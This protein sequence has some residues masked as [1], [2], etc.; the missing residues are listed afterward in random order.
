MLLLGLL[1]LGTAVLFLAMRAVAP[2]KERRA[3]VKVPVAVTSS[4]PVVV[5]TDPVPPV[6]DGKTPPP[7]IAVGELNP[8]RAR[9][10]GSACDARNFICVNNSA[11]N[12]LFDNPSVVTGTAIAFENTI[13]WKL[14]DAE[15]NVI[16]S[17]R[18]RTDA[19]D[20]GQVG[21]FSIRMFWTILP[22]TSEGTFSAYEL[23]ASDG[24]V[25]HA[26]SIPVRFVKK[27]LMTRS[28]FFL[29]EAAA[30]TDCTAVE[31]SPVTLPASVF[32]AEATLR[33]LL[34]TDSSDAPVGRVTQIPDRTGLVSLTVTN[35]VADVVFD[36]GLERDGGGS[37]HVGAIRAQ[38]ERTLKQFSSVKTVSIRVQGKSA[39]ETLQP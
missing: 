22:R 3:Y 12:K 32:P 1:L 4:V 33:A 15:G 10:D 35:G 7:S 17:G 19:P 18:T 5:N 28:V 20:A 34:A 26:V 16:S 8:M 21:A 29:P 24:A 36:E 9:P 25:Q 31:A 6:V 2:I 23:S 11:S 39:D 38:I 14:E 30:Q 27:G 37:C 13:N